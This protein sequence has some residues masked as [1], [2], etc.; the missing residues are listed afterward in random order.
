MRN[1]LSKGKQRKKMEAGEKRKEVKSQPAISR[2]NFN[3]CENFYKLVTLKI[4]K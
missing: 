2:S 4:G 1:V 3:Q